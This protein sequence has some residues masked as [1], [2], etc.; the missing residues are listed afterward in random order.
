MFVASY[1]ARPSSQMEWNENARNLIKYY[2]AIAVVENDQPSFVHHMVTKNEEMFLM[3][4]PRFLQQEVQQ[5]SATYSRP[6][7]ISM[8]APKIRSF[9]FGMLKNYLDE[10]IPLE[11]DEDGNVTKQMLGVQKILD[12]M[13]LEEIVKFNVGVN[14]DRV[15]AA[16]LAIA[17]AT[18]LDPVYGAIGT[19]DTRTLELYAAPKQKA[20]FGSSKQTFTKTRKTF[21]A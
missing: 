21:R 11:K 4:T 20:L 18:K 8:A 7:G 5:K 19:T 6:F 13:L 9:V 15:I 16:A 12:P 14:T 2:N 10:E 3:E 1:T 17:V